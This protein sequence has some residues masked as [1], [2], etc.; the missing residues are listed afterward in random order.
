M[1]EPKWIRLDAV[2][3]FHAREMARR[4]GIA[5][6]RDLNLLESALARPR[7]LLA[8]GS[9]DIAAL[10]A[11]YAQ[12]IVRNHPFLD[13]NKRAALAT[14]RAF[15]LIN[16]YALNASQEEKADQVLKLAASEIIEDEFAKWV[17]ERLIT[18]SD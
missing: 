15:L 13:G 1:N 3:T 18:R 7:N 12:G 2:L 5:G 9:P 8:Y 10:A 6:V 17:R 11:S 14:C 16:G 4:G